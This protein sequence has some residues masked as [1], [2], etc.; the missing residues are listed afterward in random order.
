[1]NKAKR[2]YIIISVL[3][4]VIAVATITLTVMGYLNLSQKQA[5][6]AEKKYYTSK[7]A[8]K[9][10]LLT[11]L[12]QRYE[13][14]KEDVPLID[15]A[16]PSEKETS[17][18]LADLSSQAESSGLK[19]TFLR[20]DSSGSS[21]KTKTTQNKA[22]GD[23]SLLQT[24]KGTIGYELPLIIKVS[25]SYA[26]FL[27]FIGKIENYQRLINVEAIG[28]DKQENDKISDYVEATL[29]VKAYLKNEKN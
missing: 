25:G 17:N 9:Q 26:K 1:M 15:N 13:I 7:M 8:E 21:A 11:T 3:I 20:P 19:L 14:I 18:L 27:T 29:N 28:I 2:F 10:Q 6:I 16:L 24:V 22:V 5:A 4:S 12:E 23:L